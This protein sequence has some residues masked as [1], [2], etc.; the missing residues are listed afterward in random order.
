MNQL[1]TDGDEF[2]N[3]GL[4]HKGDIEYI[5]GFWGRKSGNEEILWF[6]APTLIM[7]SKFVTLKSTR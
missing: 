1:K 6:E 3:D 5:D 4:L 7:L 2:V